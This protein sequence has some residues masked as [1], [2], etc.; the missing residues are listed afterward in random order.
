ML[1]NRVYL[2]VVV[3]VC[4]TLYLGIDIDPAQLAGPVSRVVAVAYK[5]WVE[6]RTQTGAV[7]PCER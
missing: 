1:K 2:R 4:V 6:T 5:M 3:C 7:C